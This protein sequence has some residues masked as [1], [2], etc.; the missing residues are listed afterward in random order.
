MSKKTHKINTAANFDVWFERFLCAIVLV[1]PFL[2]WENSL[3][4]GADLPRHAVI[5]VGGAGLMAALL[6]TISRR[7]DSN[8]MHIPLLAWPVAGF[9]IMAVASNGWAHHHG[10]ALIDTVYLSGMILLFFLALYASAVRKSF[11]LLLLRV[12]VLAGTGIAC[13]GL[14]QNFGWM[15]DMFF[16]IAPPAATM[17]NKNICAQYMDAIIFPAWFL[18]IIARNNREAWQ[19]S[20]AF[21][22]ILSMVLVSYTRGAWLG[23]L[24]GLLI[25]AVYLTINASARRDMVAFFNRTKCVATGAAIAVACMIVALPSAIDKGSLASKFQDAWQH[26]ESGS[27]SFRLAMDANTWQMFKD[28]PWGVGIG[29]WKHVYPE[30]S[31]AVRVTPGF[32]VQVEPVQLHNDP[33]VF[34]VELGWIGGLFFIS[35]FFIMVWN[36]WKISA[37]TRVACHDR[38]LSLAVLIAISDVGAHSLLSFPFHSPTSAMQIWLW[39]GIVGGISIHAKRGYAR[40]TIPMTEIRWVMLAIPAAL[41]GLFFILYNTAYLKADALI[42]NSSVF[43]IK[44]NYSNCS[45]VND[46]IE[47]K[48]LFPYSYKVNRVYAGSLYSCRHDQKEAFEASLEQLKQ[49]PFYLNALIQMMPLAYERD[50]L[51]VFKM[52]VDRLVRIFPWLPD[53]YHGLGILAW[54][55]GAY[56]EARKWFVLALEKNK[57]YPASLDMLKKI[58][59]DIDKGAKNQQK[60]LQEPK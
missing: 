7:K 2:L 46:V 39:L 13:I 58:P 14:L 16:Q 30:Y 47:A 10:S 45:W 8:T 34:F 57:H 38:L 5:E 43:V 22:L 17:V 33:F 12:S 24:V 6:F 1:V 27:A 54:R 41:G 44:Y 50:E 60:L 51:E 21:S 19:W 40:A 35:I 52:V 25:L 28:N 49:E 37:D 3:L 20:I 55:Q 23:L 15:N 48:K 18:V 53:G 9:F 29:N 4:Q 42:K 26:S 36:V 32:G 56:Q 11:P 31:R 59:P